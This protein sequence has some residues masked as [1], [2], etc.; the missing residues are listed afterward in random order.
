MTH[1]APGYMPYTDPPTLAEATADAAFD[2]PRDPNV[3]TC[4]ARWVQHTTVERSLCDF[5]TGRKPVCRWYA[6]RCQ[7][8]RA[9]DD[10]GVT[11]DPIARRHC[12]DVLEAS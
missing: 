5:C 2:P 4:V 7:H 6:D 8:G 1:H 12:C 11:F 3:T 9:V 10:P